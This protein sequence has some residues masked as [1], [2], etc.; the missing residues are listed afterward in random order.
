MYLLPFPIPPCFV[1]SQFFS[2]D[3]Y[4]V[5]FSNITVKT[6]QNFIFKAFKWFSEKNL[7]CLPWFIK[8]YIIWPQAPCDLISYSSASLAC[9]QFGHL[10]LLFLLPGRLVPWCWCGLLPY[11]HSGFYSNITWYLS[12]ALLT[13]LSDKTPFYTLVSY[14]ALLF[15]LALSLPGNTSPDKACLFVML[16]FPSKLHE[17]GDFVLFTTSQVPRKA[18]T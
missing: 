18:D 1:V 10:H 6:S 5:S 8:P 11:C 13:L 16:F 9:F 7:K 17:S 14:S 3:V 12:R 2:V 15:F 4:R